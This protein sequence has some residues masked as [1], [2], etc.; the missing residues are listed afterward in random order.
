MH[1]NRPL[2]AARNQI[3]KNTYSLGHTRMKSA[4]R[5]VGAASRG[6]RRRERRSNRSLPPSSLSL[7]LACM[8]CAASSP[9]SVCVRVC[10]SP[11]LLRDPRI[12][13]LAFA[14]KITV[15]LVSPPA[16]VSLACNTTLYLF[17]PSFTLSPTRD[18]TPPVS[19]GKRGDD[20]MT[21]C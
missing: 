9:A 4:S 7:P 20:S 6:W 21:S 14:P 3:I 19:G 12:R 8:P 13:C 11:F 16:V 15:V 1:E 18:H 17:S 2:F 10:V 5:T